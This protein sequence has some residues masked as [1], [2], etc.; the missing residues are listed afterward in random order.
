MCVLSWRSHDGMESGLCLPVCVCV[1][2]VAGSGRP[3]S[4]FTNAMGTAK[5]AA[6]IEAGGSNRVKRVMRLSAPAHADILAKLALRI[7]TEIS[8]K[9]NTCAFPAYM[10]TNANHSSIIYMLGV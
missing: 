9:G 1:S 8:P 3:L 4:E 10:M 6:G 5:H 7:S 2:H